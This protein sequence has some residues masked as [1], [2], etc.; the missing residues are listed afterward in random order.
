MDA[1]P[2]TSGS[3]SRVNEVK[4]ISL[5]PSWNLSYV[6]DGHELGRNGTHETDSILVR[7]GQPTLSHLLVLEPKTK[8]ERRARAMHLVLGR[9]TICVQKRAQG[10]KLLPEDLDPGGLG[11]VANIDQ[12]AAL[13]SM[14]GLCKMRC[15]RATVQDPQTPQTPVPANANWASFR[16]VTGLF[17][18]SSAQG[19]SSA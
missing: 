13:P 11:V 4:A 10:Q 17:R 2:P 18:S 3:R 6:D 9:D 16:C 14:P 8:S 7:E 1:T 19:S 15:H 12:R 5:L